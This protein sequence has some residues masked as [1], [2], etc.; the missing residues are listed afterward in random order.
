[1]KYHFGDSDLAARRL[2]MLAE[3]F[4]PTTEAFIRRAVA[5]CAQPPQA[6]ADLGCGPGHTTHLLARANDCAGVVG[7]DNSPAFIRLAE[8]TATPGVRFIQ[9]DVTVTPLPGGPFDLLFCRFLLTHL[10]RPLDALAAWAT[11]LSPHG[12]LL[13]EETEAIHTTLPAFEQYMD[14]VR[15]MLEHGG[16]KLYVANEISG[17][18]NP[19]RSDL[20]II[21]G[22]V[23]T[24][25][26]MFVMNMQAWKADPFV[27]SHAG[28]VAVAALEQELRS[29]A[30]GGRG[31]HTI[32]WHLRQFVFAP[33]ANP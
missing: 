22:A 31:E 7:F 13:V 15:A 14:I 10:H 33:R 26:E 20:A 3:M 29:L 6:A 9:H 12:L 25:A 17:G 18:A 16:K 4:A 19:R 32:E 27:R 1:M 21:P 24:V 30:A 2:G 28:A 11:Q 23:A 8:T 5:G